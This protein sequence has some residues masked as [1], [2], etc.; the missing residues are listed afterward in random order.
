MEYDYRL[1]ASRMI[2]T[3]SIRDKMDSEDAEIQDTMDN[4]ERYK[5]QLDTLMRWAHQRMVIAKDKAKSNK[6]GMGGVAGKGGWDQQQNNN[7]TTTSWE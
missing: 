3:D 2:A 4:E 7:R 1:T 5:S 6:M